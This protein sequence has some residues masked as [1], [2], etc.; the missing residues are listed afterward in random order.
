MTALTKQ[1]DRLTETEIDD[2]IVVMHLDTGEFY[3]FTGTA[4][5]IWRLIDGTRCGAEVAGSLSNDYDRG[6][7]DISIEVDQFIAE[8]KELGLVANS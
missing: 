5:A 4:A 3:S 6:K 7:T 8:L 1:N 2:E